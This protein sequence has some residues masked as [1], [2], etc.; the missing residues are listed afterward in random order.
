MTPG[1]LKPGNSTKRSAAKRGILLPVCVI[2][3]Q[4]PAR[5]ITEGILVSGRF[6]CTRCEEEIVCAQVG[7]TRYFDLK[8][9]IKR[10]WARVKP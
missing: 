10:I 4:T 5:G 3:E 1:K 7:E 9:K 8:E 6:L 2:C